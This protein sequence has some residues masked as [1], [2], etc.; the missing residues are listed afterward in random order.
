MVR[1]FIFAAAVALSLSASPALSGPAGDTLK[2][3]LYSGAL[4]DGLGKL[5]PLAAGGD[6][7]A[8]FGVGTIRLTQTLEKFTQTLYRHGF[9]FP[10]TSALGGRTPLTVPQNPDPEP[11]DYNGVRR[12]LGDLVEGLDN[13]RTSF[14]A[15]GKSDDYV[16]E[17]NPLKIR[18]D[19]NGDGKVDD[20]E[21]FAALFARW[22][23]VSTQEL[24]APA[25]PGG[26]PK[27]EAVGLDRADAYWLAGYTEVLAAQADFLLAHD[28]SSFVNA[29]FHRVFPKA[30]FPM[31]AYTK[32]NGTLVLG[33]DADSGIADAIAAIHTISWPV[34]DAPRL[35]GVRERLK[36]VL[37]Y[38][39]QDWDAIMAET[40]D[41][42]ELLPSPKQTPM[43]PGTSI[44]DDRVAAWRAT[45]DEADK[46]LDGTLLVPHWRFS[47]G[48]DL[49][50]YFETAKRTD[51]VMLLTG[52]DAVPF[53]RD[54]PV[55]SAADFGAVQAAFG[56][57]WLA[58]AFWF[59]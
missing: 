7:E 17:L 52:L 45:L 38:S 53:L 20:G 15:A 35:S 50:A 18:V 27:F 10:D 21:S 19:A 23:N 8:A 59:N 16:I 2:D 47:K 3:A 36:A 56:N 42:H 43:I 11:F 9:D 12:M 26:P 57:D 46:L 30:G 34:I 55:A 22:S 24:L 41:D 13:A 51:L 33:P 31:Q 32:G 5:E 37:A 49:K 6:S 39:R 48:F 1:S 58:Y 40:D 44:T 54:G 28:F 4:V 14:D 25:A 29:T